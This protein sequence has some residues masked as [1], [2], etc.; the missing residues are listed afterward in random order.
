[1]EHAA[2]HELSPPDPSARGIAPP[3]ADLSCECGTAIGGGAHRV[4]WACGRDYTLCP[5]C[6]GWNRNSSGATAMR[7]G[8]C[9]RYY[10][11]AS[12][13]RM[14]NRFEPT[15]L[16]TLKA[17]LLG[18]NGRRGFA[19]VFERYGPPEPCARALAAE[20]PPPGGGRTAPRSSADG[21]S[22]GRRS[23]AA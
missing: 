2:R 5:W 12:G 11:R 10:H 13:E 23:R 14:P 3:A 22:G 9:D 21:G 4:C 6:E 20:P 19:G 15:L 17:F 7:C 16:R 8:L 18:C 1:M